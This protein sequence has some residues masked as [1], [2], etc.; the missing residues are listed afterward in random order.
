MQIYQK[1]DDK[2]YAN[3]KSHH[4]NTIADLKTRNVKRKPQ[5]E[6]S[7]YPIELKPEKKTFPTKLL[8]DIR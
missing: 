7:R 8:V 1:D 4:K 5:K 6:I 2:R 3:G